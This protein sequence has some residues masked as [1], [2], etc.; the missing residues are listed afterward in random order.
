MFAHDSDLLHEILRRHSW[1][2]GVF[3]VPPVGLALLADLEHVITLEGNRN[4]GGG[5][6]PALAFSVTPEAVGRFEERQVVA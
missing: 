2:D 1:D 3:T 6:S 5:A 4:T